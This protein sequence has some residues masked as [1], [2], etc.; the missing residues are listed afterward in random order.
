MPVVIILFSLTATFGLILIFNVFKDRKPKEILVLF[1]GIFAALGIIFL[2]IVM[3]RENKGTILNLGLFL[4]VAMIGFYMLYREFFSKQSELLKSSVP[5]PVALAHG[6]AA[7][8]SFI[9]LLIGYLT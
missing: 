9:I 1:H 2:L 5:K 3:V 7:V 4:L 8:I 6:L